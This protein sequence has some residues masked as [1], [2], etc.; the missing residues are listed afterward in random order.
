MQEDEWHFW[1]THTAFLHTN[2]TPR[3]KGTDN[4]VWRRVKLVTWDVTIPDADIDD[5]LADKLAREAPGILNWIIAGARQW[6]QDGLNEPAAVRTATDAYRA[7]EDHIGRFLTDCATLDPRWST[8]A[9]E[10]REAYEKWCASNGED[11]WSPQALGRGLT[12]LGL[13]S[14]RA[15]RGGNRAWR[16]I[17]LNGE[18]PAQGTWVTDD[19]ASSTSSTNGGVNLPYMEQAT[20]SVTTNT[21]SVQQTG[22]CEQVNENPEPDYLAP[23]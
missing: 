8:P 3:I 9:S 12:K 21:S 1:P 19:D 23:F 7:S 10:L 22:P 4:G 18:S 16:G 6:A 2:N 17:S 15:G 11:A 13:A 5:H 14:G 20:P